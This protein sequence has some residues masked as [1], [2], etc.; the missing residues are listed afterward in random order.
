MPKLDFSHIGEGPKEV[1]EKLEKLL[2]EAYNKDPAKITSTELVG[3]CRYYRTFT[4]GEME[5]LIRGLESGKIG[6]DYHY[7]PPIDRGEIRVQRL[8]D[9][10]EKAEDLGSKDL[11]LRLG[12][13]E[14]KY[15]RILALLEKL[16]VGSLSK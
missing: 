7:D 2:K 12:A 14:D 11:S 3:W 5:S 13:L 15:D 10:E 6:V 8:L 16:D 1:G 4:L 9:E